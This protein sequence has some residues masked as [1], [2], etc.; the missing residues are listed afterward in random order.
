MKFKPSAF[1][2][3]ILLAL[4]V[5]PLAMPVEAA[6]PPKLAI[7]GYDPVA[8]FTEKRPVEGK[9]E[10]VF[11]WDGL[12]YQ[13]ASAAHRG[14]FAA[15]PDRYA[16]NY[17]GN[18]AGTLSFRAEQVPADPLYWLISDGRLYLF[19]GAMGRKLIENNRSLLKAADANWAAIRKTKD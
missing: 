6:D 4:F 7:R 17:G 2:A 11:V 5:F 8:Y 12:R 13:F 18:C 14:L 19:A 9:P 10:F 3:R 16:P 15:D 1:A